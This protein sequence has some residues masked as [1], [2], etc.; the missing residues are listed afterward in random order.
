MKEQAQRLNEFTNSWNLKVHEE[1]EK[2]AE[3]M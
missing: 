3:T 1:S 2:M